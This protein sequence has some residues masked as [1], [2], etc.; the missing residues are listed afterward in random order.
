[1]LEPLSFIA[2]PSEIDYLRSLSID[3][4]EQGW[5]DF[6]KRRDPSPDTPRNEV[7]LEFFRR[8]RYAERNFQG[9]GPGW[10]SDMGAHLHP[11]R[12]ARADRDAAADGAIRPAGDLVLQQP[13]SPVRLHRSGRIRPLRAA[14]DERMSRRRP[15]HGIVTLPTLDVRARAAHAAELTTQLLMGETVRILGR[16]RTGGW[17]RVRNDADDY[18]GWTRG[19]GLVEASERRVRR[20]LKAATARVVE[21]HASVR[22]SP[23]SDAVVTPLCWNARVIAGRTRGGYRPVELPDG[24]RG[25]TRAATLRTTL[26]KPPSLAARARSLLGI[27]YL[28]GGRSAWAF[29]CSG[30]TQQ[31]LAEQGVEV[32]RDA[33]QQYRASLR[34]APAEPSREGD[35]VFF[36]GPDGRAAHVGLMLGGGYYIQARGRVRTSSLESSNVL[37]D[38]ELDGT[39]IGIRRPV[40]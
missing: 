11:P 12:S 27:P 29:D 3:E 37:F 40:R 4:Q 30:L 5:E 31:M 36:S 16:D 24:R 18:V 6:W 19:W 21:V 10:R 15:S 35:L 32:P 34:L 39:L 14:A 13:V 28:W 1:M 22:Q 38:K 2:E 23:R 25:W 7:Q 33:S 17:L 9:F 26:R 8:V 20:W